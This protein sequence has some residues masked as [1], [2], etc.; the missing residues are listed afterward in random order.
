[1][2]ELAAALSEITK[3]PRLFKSTNPGFARKGNTMQ[4]TNTNQ[5]LCSIIVLSDGETWSRFGN[6]LT[7]TQ[8]AYNRLLEGAEIRDLDRSDIV[9]QS[10]I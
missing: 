1:L 4:N 8:D 6:I 10:V 3:E 5:N 2:R 7:I 9:K